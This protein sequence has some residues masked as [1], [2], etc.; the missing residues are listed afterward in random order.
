MNHT[1]QLQKIIPYSQIQ[2]SIQDQKMDIYPH[3]W[4]EFEPLIYLKQDIENDKRIIEISPRTTK[5]FSGDYIIE[6]IAQTISNQDIRSTFLYADKSI[7]TAIHKLR[8]IIPNYARSMFHNAN[9]NLIISNNHSPSFSLYKPLE[10][11]LAT[12]KFDENEKLI[13]FQECR[14][15]QKNKGLTDLDVFRELLEDK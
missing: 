3:G 10:D 1:I 12:L 2:S 5:Y 9:A 7:P 11:R 15:L 8:A 4:K 6:E 13:P 14:I